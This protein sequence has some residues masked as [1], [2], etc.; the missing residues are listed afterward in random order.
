MYDIFDDIYDDYSYDMTPEDLDAELAFEAAMSIDSYEPA[1]EGFRD[2]MSNIGTGIQNFVRNA[3]RKIRELFEKVGKFIKDRFA[4]L[5]LKGMKGDSATLAGILKRLDRRVNSASPENRAKVKGQA[6]KIKR[7]IMHAIDS[8]RSAI[9]TINRTLSDSVTIF[10]ALEGLGKQFISAM[11]A[12]LD[13]GSNQKDDYAGNDLAE[14][15]NTLLDKFSGIEGTCISTWQNVFDD[16]ETPDGIESSQIKDIL[17][18]VTKEKVDFR[19]VLAASAICDNICERGKDACGKLAAR[20]NNMKRGFNVSASNTGKANSLRH[21]NY[22]GD[23][24]TWEGLDTTSGSD[25][26]KN[27]KF[28]NTSAESAKTMCANWNRYASAV[29]NAANM[30]YKIKTTLESQGGSGNSDVSMKG[31]FAQQHSAQTNWAGT[32]LPDET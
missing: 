31:R 6:D 21:Y 16:I 22:T 30:L 19:A 11:M 2:V 12:K 9:S 3:I 13:P 32:E 26:D 15:T 27:L 14:R 10:K 1:Y 29:S 17:R 5:R 23:D 24:A 4:G 18:E 20:V 28:D 25:D 8:Q 7:A